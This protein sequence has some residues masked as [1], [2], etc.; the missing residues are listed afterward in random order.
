MHGGRPLPSQAAQPRPGLASVRGGVANGAGVA[1]SLGISYTPGEEVEVWSESEQKWV[2]GAVTRVEGGMV[3]VT[4]SYPSTG[5][6]GTK[7]IPLGHPAIRRRGGSD[8]SPPAHQSP[9]SAVPL[10]TMNFSPRVPHTAPSPPPTGRAPSG[11]THAPPQA[12]RA[13]S[14]GTHAPP[15]AGRAPSGGTAAPLGTSTL[16]KPTGHGPGSGPPTASI[17]ASDPRLAQQ[18]KTAAGS[19][20]PALGGQP[21][22]SSSS[23]SSAGAMRVG[24]GVEIWSDSQG[25]WLHGTVDRVDGLII[26]VSYRYPDGKLV[27]KALPAGHKDLRG[28]GAFAMNRAVALAATA[29]ESDQEREVVMQIMSAGGSSSKHSGD[30]TAAQLPGGG[31]YDELLAAGES[32]RLLMEL[33]RMFQHEPASEAGKQ[34]HRAGQFHNFQETYGRKVFS[35]QAVF[36]TLQLGRKLWRSS[37]NV[38]RL[39]VPPHGRLIIVGDTHGQLEDVLWMFFKYGQPSATNQYLF[40]GDIVDRGGHALEIL[41]LLLCTKRDDPEC[42]HIL[43][44]N[45]ED[46]G[47]CMNFGFQS[48]LDSKFGPGVESGA[49]MQE[50]VVNF[51]PVLPVAAVVSD[52]RKE[53]SICVVHGGVPVGIPGMRRPVTLDG[54]VEA[55]NRNTP[56]VVVKAQAAG[57]QILFNMLWADPLGPDVTK[58]KAGRGNVFNESDT[59][60]F[61]SANQ[62]SAVV[63]AHQPPDDLGFHGQGYCYLHGNRCITVFSAS[64]YCGTIGNRGA[65]L[66][67]SGDSFGSR[68]PKH[69]EHW[70]PAWP[71][72]AKVLQRHYEKRIS[73]Y[74]KAAED[75]EREAQMLATGQAPVP[76][77]SMAVGQSAS[78]SSASAPPR[79]SQHIDALRQ[80]VEGMVIEKICMRKQAL[81]RAFDAADPKHHMKVP[82]SVWQKIMQENLS[83][84]PAPVWPPMYEHWLLEDPVQ[85]VEF[86]HRFQVVAEITRRGSAPGGD[87]F[88]SLNKVRLKTSDVSAKELL[89]ALGGDSLLPV[90]VEDFSKFLNSWGAHLSDTQVRS[91]YNGIA[92]YLRRTPTVEDVLLGIALVSEQEQ[93][94][95]NSDI[96]DLAKWLGDTIPQRGRSLVGFFINYDTDRNGFLTPDEFTDAI[97]HWQQGRS[98]QLQP[99]Q[100]SQLLQFI[101]SQGTQNGRIGLIEFL[102]ALGPRQFAMELASLLLSNVLM[103]LYFYQPLLLSFC[104]RRRVSN[105]VTKQDFYEALAEMGN[106]MKEAGEQPLAHEQMLTICDIAAGGSRN[107]QFKEFLNSLRAVDIQQRQQTAAAALNVALGSMGGWDSAANL[108]GDQVAPIR[109]SSSLILSDSDI[110]AADSAD[111][112]DAQGR[113]AKAHAHLDKLKNRLHPHVPA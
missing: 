55:L 91:L 10:G 14:G 84:L 30:E 40:N 11:G 39:Q 8:A 5:K 79:A 53:R 34:P 107:I 96:R 85:Y 72:L 42:L 18:R 61:C 22:G 45:H 106:R 80:Q 83:E 103:P 89:D 62:V 70:A 57:E 37:R 52:A 108:G 35:S 63:R 90:K 111:G 23:S 66:I 25:K 38:A 69:S 33:P 86:L 92:V 17:V 24:D 47:I 58:V 81:F 94:R 32:A 44:G 101:D 60:D 76:M 43:R 67:C 59:M 2:H 87:Y 75:A 73:D 28:Y 88:H 12:G 54:D 105:T 50:C 109:R 78:S 16:A 41:L 98:R 99:Q 102:Q 74:P 113:R 71:Q 31:R 7:T 3:Y 56:S 36:R 4:Y 104:D 46:A 95:G 77:G 26:H 65:V 100:I 21:G 82:K 29:L 19:A 20:P 27:S 1:G 15:Q 112:K 48:E 68:G 97:N 13:P 93:S 64:N 49:I 9:G 51:F 6:Q 110:A